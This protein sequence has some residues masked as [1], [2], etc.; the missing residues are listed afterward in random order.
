MEFAPDKRHRLLAYL[1]YHGAWMSRERLA[2]LFWPTTSSRTARRN[3]RG[4]LLRTRALPWSDGLEAGRHALRWQV[5]TDVVAF[6][7]HAAEGRLA[8]AIAW[9]EGPLL[10]GLDSFDP[11]GFGT[12]L[13]FERAHRAQ[14]R[15]SL[16]LR[17]AAVLEEAGRG[18]AAMEVLARALDDPLD[19]E[20]LQRYMRCAVDVG[21]MGAA[22]RAFDA[23]ERSL[24]RELGLEPS[25]A[26]RQLASAIR[27]GEAETL[28]RSGAFDHRG[29][30][31]GRPT[32]RDRAPSAVAPVWIGRQHEL[33]AIAALLERPECRMLTIVGPGGVGKSR[34]ALELVS[35]Y[36]PDAGGAPV[37]VGLG[38][39][40]SASDVSTRVA[41]ALHVELHGDVDRLEQLA[42]RIDHTR[43]LLMLDDVDGAIEAV[44]TLTPLLESCPNLQIVLTSRQRVDVPEA[45]HVPLH[46]MAFPSKPPRDVS[47]ALAFDAVRLFVERAER[48][49]PSFALRASDLPWVQAICRS[50]DGFPLGLELAATWVRVMSCERIAREIG[51]SLDFL[52]TAP[53]PG[54]E[55]HESLRST[56]EHSWRLLR[57]HERTALADLSVFRGGFT[58]DAAA[59][60]A[61]ASLT[62]LVALVDKSLLACD[63]DD[64][65]RFHP[66]VYAY[67]REKAAAM[68]ERWD[69]MRDRHA[70]F[71]LQALRRPL[72]HGATVPDGPTPS[73]DENVRSAWRHLARRGS[74]EAIAAS[75]EPLVAYVERRACFQDGLDLLEHVPDDLTGEGV[76]RRRVRIALRVA[77]AVLLRRLGRHA[78]AERCARAGLAA[79]RY[80]S[81]DGWARVKAHETLGFTASFDARVGDAAR[82]WSA[83]LAAAQ[84]YGLDAYALELGGLLGWAEA[85]TDRHEAAERRARTLLDALAAGTEPASTVSCLTHVGSIYLATAKPR[86]AERV[87]R[88]AL[89][90]ARSRMETRSVAHL[91]FALGEAAFELGDFERAATLCDEATLLAEQQGEPLTV[92]WA[93]ALAGRAAGAAGDVER[94]ERRLGEAAERAWR[95]R[96]AP[97]AVTAA[98]Y[99]AETRWRNGDAAAAGEIVRTVGWHPALAPSLRPVVERL[100]AALGEVDEAPDEAAR[101]DDPPLTVEAIVEHVFAR[102]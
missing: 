17:H 78:E 83:A 94:S 88:R 10:M 46:G 64:R 56:F 4:L 20:V 66:L 52:A 86:L 49:R 91:T 32:S 35:R 37:V 48:A 3:L 79:D 26:T 97:A 23:F 98:V 29:T 72:G 58:A 93:L 73:A 25:A 71:Y 90:A 102:V 36:A 28:R 41:A 33:G 5:A 50:L 47:D 6:E 14:R 38:D 84:R 31:A 99:L 13:E 100:R 75:I 69:A 22:L 53:A 59:S 45:W 80:A 54:L 7:T 30:R 60:V 67:A 11:D 44:A 2:D 61:A 81:G 27:D 89:D 101:A 87:F 9:H 82:H 40:A 70:S 43:T 57:A 39:A 34:L 24:E 1:A 15:R 76:E 74:A 19:E 51:A 77:K 18:R 63:G 55:R 21:D 95:I 42:L 85:V 65:Y 8:E 12:W 62:V 16:V 92:S 96:N 68:P